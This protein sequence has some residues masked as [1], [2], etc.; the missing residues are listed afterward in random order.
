MYM[1]VCC[2][3]FHRITKSAIEIILIQSALIELMSR[4]VGI[5]TI[6]RFTRS[7][8]V[9]DLCASSTRRL[10]TAFSTRSH[11]KC[12]NDQK[13]KHHNNLCYSPA[14]SVHGVTISFGLAKVF[15]SSLNN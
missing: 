3:P 1:Y 11:E 8:S 12:L 13:H 4:D 15:P 2:V 7:S 10:L 14:C 6:F 5:E 9:N